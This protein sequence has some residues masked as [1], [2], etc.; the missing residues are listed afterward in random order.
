M[1]QDANGNW[2]I[3]TRHVSSANRAPNEL[4]TINKP[5]LP[6]GRGCTNMSSLWER[7]APAMPK[8]WAELAS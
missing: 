5:K 3:D 8:H 7:P 4:A 2:V 6:P 1:I